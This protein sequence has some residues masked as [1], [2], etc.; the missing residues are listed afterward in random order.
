MLERAALAGRRS[1]AGEGPVPR[2]HARAE[3]RR[4][5][6]PGPAAGAGARASAREP[7]GDQARTYSDFHPNR[8]RRRSRPRRH[9]PIRVRDPVAPRPDVERRGN[10]GELEREHLVG[11]G[12]A[13]PAVGPDG[14]RR[15]A[16]SA[17]NR[18]RSSSGA[19]NRPC[20]P[21]RSGAG[22]LTAPGMWPATGSIGSTSPRNRSGARASISTPARASEAAAAASSNGIPPA[23]GDEVPGL[24][25]GHSPLDGVPGRQPAT[26]TPIQNPNSRVPEVAE[27]P[28]RPR[29]G[30]RVAGVVDDH[31]PVRRRRPRP[32]SRART[33]RRPEA[34]GGHP[35]PGGPASAVSRS[36]NTAPGM[37]PARYSSRPG[38]RGGWGLNSQRT[39]RSAGGSPA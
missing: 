4:P 36:T 33:P 32:A 35:A 9:R 29:R 31:R 28:P 27:H 24:G 30:D 37:C 2:D 14:G 20:S 12:D 26:E 3:G 25:R 6:H 13:R 5:G 16:P 17:E 34:G 38:G 1:Q 15:S 21:T 10:A 11:R 39:S 7:F 8:M 18:A 19:R 22:R 23:R